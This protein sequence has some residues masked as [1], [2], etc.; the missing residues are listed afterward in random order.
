MQRLQKKV[1]KSQ[2]NINRKTN[3]WQPLSY[4]C[5]LFGANYHLTAEKPFIAN[6]KVPSQLYIVKQI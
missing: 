5:W 4:C 6:K 2:M 1:T 3:Q